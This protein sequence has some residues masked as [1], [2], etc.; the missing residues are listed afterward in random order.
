MVVVVAALELSAVLGLVVVVVVLAALTGVFAVLG[1]G[2]GLVTVVVVGDDDARVLTVVTV[3]RTDLR[4]LAG[5]MFRDLVSAV[6][7]FLARPSA[8]LR[9]LGFATVIKV[10]GR[11][12]AVLEC[13][14]AVTGW[15]T[16][17]GLGPVVVTTDE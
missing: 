9:G 17:S 1:L 8:P 15:P 13:R 4:W 12:K 16:C 14:A 5:L 3:V 6:R 10:L 7:L 11:V 2:L